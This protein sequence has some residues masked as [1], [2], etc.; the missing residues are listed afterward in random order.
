M[1]DAL[2]ST[3]WLADRLSPPQ[4]D[5]LRIVDVPTSDDGYEQGHI[6]RAVKVDWKRELIPDEDESSG[7]VIDPDRFAALARRLGIRPDSEV[8]FYGDQGGRHALRALW[9][10]EY[11]KHRGPLHFLDGGRER[12]RAENRPLTDEPSPVEPSDYPTPSGRANI[13]IR[14]DEILARLPDTNGKFVVLDVRT[15]DEYSG[16]DVR[17]ARGGHIPGAINIDWQRSLRPAGSLISEKELAQLYERI[18]RDATVA[19]HCQLGVR[20]SHT[21]F[22]LKHVLG[23]PDVRNYDGSWAEW[24]NRDDTP[25]EA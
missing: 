20:A 9:T 8:V 14:R 17:S 5:S 10:F 22:V 24:G 19:V 21:W 13:R 3:A 25:V 4:A 23:Y 7:D 18:P 11:Y 6:P 1:S 15:P 12:W 16:A 2:V